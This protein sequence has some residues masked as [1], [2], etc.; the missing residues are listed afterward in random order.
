MESAAGILSSGANRLKTIINRE[1]D[2]F[3]DLLK[4]RPDWL[5]INKQVPSAKKMT[6]VPKLYIDYSWKTGNCYL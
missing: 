6:A 4:I 1:R 5:L 2:Y 3:E